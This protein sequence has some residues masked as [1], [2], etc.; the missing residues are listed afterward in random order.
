MI[1]METSLDTLQ[2]QLSEHYLADEQ[3]RRTSTSSI[4]E[5]AQRLDQT[6][7]AL[8]R[9][10]SSLEANTALTQA[11]QSEM[12]GYRNDTLPVVH[13]WDSAARGLRM[14]GKFGDG[15][16][17]LG[18]KLFWL[19]KVSLFLAACYG[20]LQALLKGEAW[21]QVVVDFISKIGH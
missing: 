17:W 7:D 6:S 14:I 5:L 12:R 16:V 4:A 1:V 20:M 2:R 18:H 10:E 9:V 21:R 13:A 15:C 19:S 11:V 3:M 8:A